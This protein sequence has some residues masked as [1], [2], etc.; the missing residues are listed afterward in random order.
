VNDP[1]S[2]SPSTHISE[3]YVS[4]ALAPA[5]GLTPI[6]INDPAFAIRYDLMPL[7]GALHNPASY[8]TFARHLFFGT[9]NREMP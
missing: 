6:L 3:W 9:D 7:A 2:A 5:L 8:A 4:P 1:L